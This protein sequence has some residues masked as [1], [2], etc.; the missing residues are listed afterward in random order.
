MKKCVINIES[1]KYY[2]R[3]PVDTTNDPGD[4]QS[5]E[6]VAG[7]TARYV[8]GRVVCIFLLYGGLV[9]GK[10]V[11]Q[12]MSVMAVTV[13]FRPTRQPKM[14]ARSLMKVVS[15]LIIMKDSQP[16]QMAGGGTMAKSTCEKG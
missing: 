9:G 4:A 16:P 11:P 1:K 13:S 7:V 3:T 2:L 5:H 12:V 15:M 8:A 14:P 10:Q 6:N